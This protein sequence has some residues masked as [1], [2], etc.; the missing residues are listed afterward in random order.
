VFP[1]VP[2]LKLWPDAV[3]ALGEVPEILP[4]LHPLFEKRARRIIRKFSQRPLDLKCIYVLAV[5][6]VAAIEP[7]CPQEALRDLIRHWYG[8][9]FG[10]ELLQPVGLPSFFLQCATLART[11]PVYRLQRPPSLP[12]LPVTAQLVEEH[13]ARPG[14][15]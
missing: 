9:R 4:Q 15:S 13:L 1:G 2:Q 10:M 8:A 12:T 5:G 3:A 6:S 7:L 14:R 11:I